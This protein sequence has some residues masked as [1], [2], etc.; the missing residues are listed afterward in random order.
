[1]GQP[2]PKRRRRWLLRALAVPPLV[3]VVFVAALPWI[4][5]LPP[6]C[7]MILQRANQV[8]V[9]STIEFDTLRTSWTG[10]VRLTGLVLRD[11]QNK[12]VVSAPEARLDRTLL[13]LAWGRPNYGTL[14][15]RHA[16][17]DIERHE[18]GSIDLAKALAPIIGSDSEGESDPAT[19][20]TLEVEDGSLTLRS[21]ELA[22][23]LTAEDL[24]MTLR[25]PR[26]PG[27]LNWKIQLANS[28][29]N[30]RET[31][32]I[33]GHY[34]QRAATGTMTDL[35]LSLSGE[36]WPLAISRSG[37]L[38]AARFDGTIDLKQDR[39]GLRLSGNAR[40]IEP[41]IAGSSLQGDHLLLDHI[42]GTWNL[43]QTDKVWRIHRIQRNFAHRHTR[44]DV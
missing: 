22:E 27:M 11:P 16:K 23:P 17:V 18:D 7:W 37:V 44:R 30:R 6:V 29:K 24:D 19:D 26:A 9:P 12:A 40:L 42:T 10:P 2:T 32:R 5:G 43:E 15:L 20:F 39:D 8:V 34:N 25:V 41:D 31:L 38:A 21:P 4:L 13:Q 14:M 33:E 28:G 36:N 1:M 35:A 3:L